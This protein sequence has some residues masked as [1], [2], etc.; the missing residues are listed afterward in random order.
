M[1]LRC[2]LH[3][4]SALSN[5]ASR[6]M[7]IARIVEEAERAGL[8]T[9]GIADHIDRTDPGREAA[10]LANFQTVERLRPAINVLIGCETTQ[11][12]PNVSRKGDITHLGGPE[13]GDGPGRDAQSPH[14]LDGVDWRPDAGS[15]RT[16]PGR[17]TDRTLSRPVRQ[18]PWP[19][20][21]SPDRPR[22]CRALAPL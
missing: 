6:E 11:I 1:K 19:H 10:V 20:T 2:N 12:R 17:P 8:Q 3:I 21:H 9:I 16:P 15:A 7:T 4:H 22:R 14:R 13:G 18:L 5:C